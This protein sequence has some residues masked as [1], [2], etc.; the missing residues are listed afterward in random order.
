MKK[1]LYFVT[2]NPGKFTEVAHYLALHASSIELKQLSADI[3]EIQTMDQRAIAIDKAKKAWQL[4]HK[5]VL[6]DD[7]AVYFDRYQQ[8][9][10]TLSKFVSTGLGFEGIK[11]LFDQGDRAY[12]L[13]Y[14]V[15]MDGPDQIYVFEGKTEGHLVKPERFEGNPHLPYD[16]FFVPDGQ[17]M[18][19]EE[20]IKDF[21]TYA[22]Y[23]YRIRALQSFLLWYNERKAA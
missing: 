6:I 17:T 13:L 12:F 20:M 7:A 2:T 4:L 10:G 22:S 16:V 21:D 3:E 9:P 19:C 23:F 1:E 8:F 5:P 14:M 15:Y 11:R 18:T